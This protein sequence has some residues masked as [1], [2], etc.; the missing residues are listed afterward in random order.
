MTQVF[1]LNSAY[2]VMTA[3]AA[4]DAGVIPPP[5]SGRVLVTVNAA[6]IPEAAE[7]IVDAPDLESLRTGFDRVVNLN[8]LLAPERPPHWREDGS[9]APVLERLLRA[10]WGI[11]TAPVELFLQSPQVAPSRVFL[12]LFPG[13]PVTVV[14]D[15]LMTY[16]PLR[17]RWPQWAAAR[18]VGVV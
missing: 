17:S 12:D 13:A 11:G 1:V 8:A 7:G 9:D 6:I 10:A 4:I 5:T 2:G 18:V 16:S 3:V 14:G 15:G